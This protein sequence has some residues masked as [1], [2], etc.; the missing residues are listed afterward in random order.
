[1][2]IHT[3]RG[4]R[5]E[6]RRTWAQDVLRLHV[7]DDGTCLHCDATYGTAPHWPCVPARIALLYVGAPKP[8]GSPEQP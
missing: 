4:R 2:L 3:P 7:E 6:S 1:M 8:D 5:P